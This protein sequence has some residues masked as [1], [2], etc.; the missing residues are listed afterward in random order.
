[1]SAPPALED[2]MRRR[3]LT[4]ASGRPLNFTVS[5]HFSTSKSVI[6][7]VSYLAAV[8]FLLAGIYCALWIVSSASLACTAC[9]CS[10]S[11]FASSLR[12]RQP[13]IAMLLT[14]LFF[15]LTI[16][17]TLFGRSRSRVSRVK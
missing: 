2:S 15:V 5:R 7:I 11:L 12:C 8:L 16:A 1:V 3:R 14:L 17:A 4:G 6:R 13:Y 10:Y 9:N